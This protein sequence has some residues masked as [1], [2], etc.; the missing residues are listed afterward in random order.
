MEPRRGELENCIG[1]HA[2]ASCIV[3]I[4]EPGRHHLPSGSQNAVKYLTAYLQEHPDDLDMR[5][6]LNVAAMTLGTYPESVP[7]QYRIDPAVFTSAEDPGRFVDVAAEKGLAATGLAGGVVIEDIDNDGLLDVVPSPVDSCA[8]LRYYH[9]ERDGSFRE[10]T[11][12]AHLSDQLGGLNL[13]ATDYNNDGR[14]DLFVMR[15]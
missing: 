7:R 13:S 11:G 8:P 1:G 4:A 10:L 2:S 14:V 9:H 15:G 12:A 3:P 6:L 5:W